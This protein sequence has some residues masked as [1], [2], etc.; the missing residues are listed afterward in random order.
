MSSQLPSQ[1]YQ[2]GGNFPGVVL[3]L[4]SGP[5]GGLGG[6]KEG[7]EWGGNDTGTDRIP[8]ILYSSILLSPGLAG[9]QEPVLGLM[10]SCRHIEFF[11]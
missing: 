9:M 10:H 2:E 8:K 5:V 1:M 11:F 4:S 6:E 7:E 3:S